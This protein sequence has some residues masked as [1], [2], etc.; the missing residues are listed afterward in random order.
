ML[1]MQGL[2]YA[3]KKDHLNAYNS[4]KRAATFAPKSGGAWV[5]Y[6]KA[7][8]DLHK[9]QESLDAFKKACKID[10]HAVKDFREVAGRLHKEKNNEWQYKFTDALSSCN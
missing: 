2:V 5:G 6:G 9:Y 4:Y 3:D 10:S 8:Y 7:A 1:S